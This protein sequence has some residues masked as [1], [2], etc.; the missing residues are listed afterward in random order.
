MSDRANLASYSRRVRMVPVSS[1]PGPLEAHCEVSAWVRFWL[2]RRS[3]VLRAWGLTRRLD[4]GV[5]ATLTFRAWAS[6]EARMAA[7]T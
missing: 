2:S 6:S 3:R 5:S 7:S 1:A 4:G